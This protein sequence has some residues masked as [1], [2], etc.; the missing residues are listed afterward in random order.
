M[1]LIFLIEKKN[2]IRQ[3][4]AKADLSILK[5]NVH[6]KSMS[7]PENAGYLAIGFTLP[8]PRSHYRYIDL[9]S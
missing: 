6:E 9:E 7:P 4:R 8:R 3:M 1:T 2:F 5:Q